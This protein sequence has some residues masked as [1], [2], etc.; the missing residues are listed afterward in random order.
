M[1]S[2]NFL[3]RL[4]SS[5]WSGVDGV[6]KILHLLLLVMLFLVFFGAM[7]GTSPILPKKAALFVQ[8]AG[9]LVEQ[10]DGN[11]YDRALA[12]LLGDAPPQTL[13]QDVIDALAFA[14]TDDR[15]SAV[16]LKTLRIPVSPLSPAPITLVR[17]VT[18]L[19]HMPTNST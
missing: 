9:P 15:I 12:E 18:T 8:P 1:S 6:R 5:I 11:P 4:I 19:P 3:V 17:P 7:S 10:L 2:S 16:H 13:V 14:K